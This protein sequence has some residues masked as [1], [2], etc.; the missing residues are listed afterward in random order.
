MKKLIKRNEEIST[1]LF[2]KKEKPANLLNSQIID[3]KNNELGKLKKEKLELVSTL[4]ELKEGNRG[5]EKELK[6]LYDLNSTR[7]MKQ[8]TP[9]MISH[10]KAGC[11][12]YSKLK[13]RQKELR[14]LDSTKSFVT[15]IQ[16]KVNI[17]SIKRRIQKNIEANEEMPIPPA[18]R[19]PKKQR[20][21][22]LRTRTK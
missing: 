2:D 12:G 11:G 1:A 13:S 5:I 19:V 18:P 22:T 3:D 10:Q 15:T 7:A 21:N 6:F 20:L 17:T 16:L 8:C 9:A 14:Q 4:N